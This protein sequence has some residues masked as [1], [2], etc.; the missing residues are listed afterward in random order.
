MWLPWAA[1]AAAARFRSDGVGGAGRAD[2]RARNLAGECAFFGPGDVLRANL[3]VAPLGGGGGRGEIRERRTDHDLGVFGFFDQ[4]PEF[5]EELRGFGGRFVHLPI[6][7]HDWFSHRIC[8]KKLPPLA[9]DAPK[10]AAT[11]WPISESD[12]RSPRSTPA[13]TFGPGTNSR[14]DSRGGAGPGRAGVEAW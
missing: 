9:I 7:R 2:H 10:L 14:K 1:A 11:V 4:R 5:L 3:N 6:A 12:A 8:G 13:R